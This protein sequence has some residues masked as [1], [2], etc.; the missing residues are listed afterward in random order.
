MRKR[1]RVKKNKNKNKNKRENKRENKNKRELENIFEYSRQTQF[2]SSPLLSAYLSIS[3]AF[4]EVTSSAVTPT[5][6]PLH[7]VPVII[8]ISFYFRVFQRCCFWNRCW[9]FAEIQY[10]VSEIRQWWN[11]WNCSVYRRL[12]AYLAVRFDQLTGKNIPYLTGIYRKIP[13]LIVI[14]QI[15]PYLTVSNYNLTAYTVVPP[16]ECL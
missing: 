16:H 7:A 12:P 4:P 5:P 11:I 3:D 8:F 13:C 15:I 1:V 2:F 10:A 9:Y 14:R 6:L